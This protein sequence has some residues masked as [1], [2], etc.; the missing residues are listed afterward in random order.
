LYLASCIVVNRG[1]R[2]LHRL[3]RLLDMWEK[4]CAVKGDKMKWV[5]V[6]FGSVAGLFALAH[7]IYFPM[8][9]LRG[10][11]VSSLM[12]SLGGLLIGAAISIALFRSAFGKK[13]VK[14]QR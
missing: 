8:L 13:E 3:S 9:L 10:E 6:F 4:N 1:L 7:C 14:G 12:G 5:K 11:H 2:G